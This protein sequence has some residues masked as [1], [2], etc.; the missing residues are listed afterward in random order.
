M[1]T[2]QRRNRRAVTV[3]TDDGLRLAVTE[4]GAGTSS[5]K[6]VLVHG[7]M[8]DS[9]FWAELVTV[10]SPRI[11]QCADV[12]AF[13]AR[14]HGK[15]DWPSRRSDTDLEVLA[16][17]LA[18]VL[19]SLPPNV[20]LV[21]HSVGGAVISEYARRY[22][23]AYA[24]R[25]RSLVMCNVAG[26]LPAWRP[27]HQMFLPATAILR[28][29]RRTLLDPVNVIG[30]RYVQKRLRK[31]SGRAKVGRAQLVPSTLP[32]DPRVFADM[33]TSLIDFQADRTYT[34]ALDQVPVRILAG[35]FDRVMTP[36]QTARFADAIHGADLDIIADAGH[37]LPMTH[38]V[39]VADA[40]VA[41]LTSVAGEMSRQQRGSIPEA[42]RPRAG[43]TEDSALTTQ[44]P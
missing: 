22:P 36:D 3:T 43:V 31:I 39:I 30:H 11:S 27:L 37:A 19:N 9:S 15:S 21:G 12:V 20:V 28:P 13:D 32:V 23:I 16:N 42:M 34:H 29:M 7:L 38:P 40:V 33:S 41:A 2:G 25:V 24:N 18:S 5:V 10:L 4:S 8:T 35:E 1:P 26:E 44:R 6:I 14:G 17:D